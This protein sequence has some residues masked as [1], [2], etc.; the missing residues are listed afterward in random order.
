[1]GDL[2]RW[3]PLWNQDVRSSQFTHSDSMGVVVLDDCAGRWAFLFAGEY[4]SEM[5]R[6]LLCGRTCHADFR[7]YLWSLHSRA[8]EE[9]LDAS[10]HAAFTG[11]ASK[12]CVERLSPTRDPCTYS[13]FSCFVDRWVSMVSFES[14]LCCGDVLLLWFLFSGSRDHMIYKVLDSPEL[15]RLRAPME[16]EDSPASQS[17]AEKSP[18]QPRWRAGT[19]KPPA[20]SIVDMPIPPVSA[21]LEVGVKKTL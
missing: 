4:S 7:A 2:P 5:F 10:S 16:I 18:L 13:C 3:M 12:R 15:T 9:G 20:G 1:M 21:A 17:S 8:E 11:V 6:D 14:F 19:L